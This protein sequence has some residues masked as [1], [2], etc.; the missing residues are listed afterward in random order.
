MRIAMFRNATIVIPAKAGIHG[1]KANS[2]DGIRNGTIGTGPWIP[3]FA[4]MT[5]GRTVALVENP[6]DSRSIA[7]QG[8][9]MR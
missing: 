4:G 8:C 7:S 5:Q 9:L 1:R 2:F 3:A 6:L